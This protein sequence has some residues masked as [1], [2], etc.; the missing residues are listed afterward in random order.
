MAKEVKEKKTTL[1]VRVRAAANGNGLEKLIG[2]GRGN[3]G[4][5]YRDLQG[6][7]GIG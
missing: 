4:S 1:E 5:P 2:N 7:C 3:K 6:T